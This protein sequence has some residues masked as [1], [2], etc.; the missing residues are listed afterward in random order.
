MRR[1]GDKHFLLRANRAV[2]LVR[3]HFSSSS[4]TLLTLLTLTQPDLNCFVQEV[5]VDVSEILMFLTCEIQSL[6]L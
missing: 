6:L 5:N 3:G 2:Q 4:L 1:E